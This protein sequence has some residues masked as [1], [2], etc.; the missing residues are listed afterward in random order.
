ME[1]IFPASMRFARTQ[2]LA[3]ENSNVP[4]RINWTQWKFYANEQMA[5][6]FWMGSLLKAIA[7]PCYRERRDL[8]EEA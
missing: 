2:Q 1:I 7:T 6:E 3:T 4:S 5:M 8:T